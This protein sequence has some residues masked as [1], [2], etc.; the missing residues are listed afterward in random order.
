MIF[1][2][3]SLGHRACD[4]EAPFVSRSRLRVFEQ[5]S[6]KTRVTKRAGGHFREKPDPSL[7]ARFS[8]SNGD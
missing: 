4:Q 3:A 2:R 6:A 7:H 5:T 8:F 1:G